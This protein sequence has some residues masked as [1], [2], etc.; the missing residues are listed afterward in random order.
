MPASVSHDYTLCVCVMKTNPTDFV[1]PDI[2]MLN[3]INRSV[4]WGSIH[5][6]QVV[7]HWAA[8]R[9]EDWD[10]GRAGRYQCSCY[11]NLST[12]QEQL[13]ES[14]SPFLLE[15]FQSK[16]SWLLPPSL[17]LQP[18]PFLLALTGPKIKHCEWPAWC[19]L[20][21]AQNEHHWWSVSL[22]LKANCATQL[23]VATEIVFLLT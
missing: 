6:F 11:W 7:S 16:P 19:C 8:W 14:S 17:F 23:P 18:E 12:Q 2:P 21:T 9:L 5:D 15:H 3:L 13:S 10:N 20:G 4:P 22:S 1:T